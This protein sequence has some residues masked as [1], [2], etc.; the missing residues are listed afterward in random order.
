[1]NIQPGKPIRVLVA[2]FPYGGTSHVQLTEWLTE[3]LIKMDRDPRIGRGNYQTWRPSENTPVTILRNQALHVALA[4]G[5]DLCLMGDE[6]LVPDFYLGKDGKAL[7]AGAVP[8]WE[9]ALDFVLRHDGPCV[10]ASP[11]CG[12]PPNEIPFCFTWSN[13]EGDQPN[14]NFQI[15]GYSRS[16]A[17]KLSG[18]QECAALPTGLMLIDMDGIRRLP[19]PYFDYEY[20][21]DGPPCRKCGVRSP[22]PRLQKAS[23]EDVFFSRNL[24][25]VGVRQYAAWNCWSAHLKTKPVGAPQP[26]PPELIP[27]WYEKA[28]LE[29]YGI[30][31]RPEPCPGPPAR[32]YPNIEVAFAGPDGTCPNPAPAAPQ[33]PR[34]LEFKLVAGAP[35]QIQVVDAA[36]GRPPSPQELAAYWAHHAPA[37]PVPAAAAEAAPAAPTGEPHANGKPKGRKNRVRAK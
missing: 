9:T 25:Y 37:P 28:V 10:V 16:E 15:V 29:K 30:K 35:G 1:V 32:P 17:A 23:T 19:H 5:F 33:V 8:F 2:T 13:T 6:D 21:G 18:V 7:R 31:M 14:A 20:V 27:V 12:P 11:Y 22:G 34:Q 4:N 3:T 26:I 24:S 36:T